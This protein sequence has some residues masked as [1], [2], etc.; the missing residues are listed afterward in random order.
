MADRIQLNE[1]DLQEVVGGAFNFFNNV[2]T[3]EPM[4]YADGIGMF[5]PTSENSKAQIIRMCAQNDGLSQQELVNM[6]LANGYL[7]QN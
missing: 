1:Q 6:A 7:T 2:H 3:G 5:K 4:C